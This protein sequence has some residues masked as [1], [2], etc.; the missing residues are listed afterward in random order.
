VLRILVVDDN[1][2]LA[3]SIVA[4][5]KIHNYSAFATVDVAKA[6]DMLDED[7]SISMVVSDVR[8]PS[9]NGLDFFRVL[10]HRFPNLPVVLMTGLPISDDDVVPRGAT[11]LEKPFEFKQLLDLIDSRLGQAK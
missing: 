9:V 1:P 3:A 4:M 2:D 8:M 10:R 11:I 5:L 6:L 7:A